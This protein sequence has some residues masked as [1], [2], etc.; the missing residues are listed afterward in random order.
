ME[1]Q[2]VDIKYI[3]SSP[4]T[5]EKI[6]VYKSGENKGKTRKLKAKPARNGL[7]PVSQKTIWT[8]VREEK[9]VKPIKMNGRTL[10]KLSDVLDWISSMEQSA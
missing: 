8:W 1:T 9:F 6:H 4:A 7:L 5:P 10:W 3:A 2:F